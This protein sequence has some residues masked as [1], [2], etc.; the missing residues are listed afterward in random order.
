M[1]RGGDVNM[2]DESAHK[3]SFNNMQGAAGA[4]RPDQAP[5]N[6]LTDRKWIAA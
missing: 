5:E 3:R 4:V 6:Q 2:W 1:A